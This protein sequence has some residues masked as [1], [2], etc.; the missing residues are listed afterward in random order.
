MQKI[1]VKARD[2]CS[3]GKNS[4]KKED[5]SLFFLTKKEKISTEK[6]VFQRI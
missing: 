1:R 6:I 2:F 4:E 5:S 3:V